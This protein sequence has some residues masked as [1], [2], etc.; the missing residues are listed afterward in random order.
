[1][2]CNQIV[3][4]ALHEL[5]I[6]TVGCYAA[7]SSSFRRRHRDKSDPLHVTGLLRGG[8]FAESNHNAGEV[9][10]QRGQ[11]SSRINILGVKHF[12]LQ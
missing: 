6:A 1:M 8:F 12:C 9:Q 2:E 7:S 5:A 4:L 3:C 11:H 10:G